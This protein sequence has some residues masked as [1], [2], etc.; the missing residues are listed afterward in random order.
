MKADKITKTVSEQEVM[1]KNLTELLRKERLISS[2]LALAV[3]MGM[4]AEQ[5]RGFSGLREAVIRWEASV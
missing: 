3:K 4:D 1:I 5:Q 2:Q